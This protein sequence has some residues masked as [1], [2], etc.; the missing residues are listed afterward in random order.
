MKAGEIA[1]VSMR[2]TSIGHPLL[3]AAALASSPPRVGRIQAFEDAP[4]VFAFATVAAAAGLLQYS[5]SSGDKGLGAFLGKEKAVNPFY[6]KDF[7][8]EAPRSPG[9][10]RGVRLPELPFVEVYGQDERAQPRRPLGGGMKQ[11]PGASSSADMTPLDR[12]Y[13]LLDDA[14]EREAYGEAAE[15]K[16]QIDALLEQR[17]GG[18]DTS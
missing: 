1:L 11:Q 8:A 9:F 18:E 15:I 6:Q 4:V 7:K 13:S 2:A 5:V 10:L 17:Q 12:L 3:T 16:T 14:I